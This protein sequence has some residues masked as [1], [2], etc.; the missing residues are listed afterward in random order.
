MALTKEIKSDKIEIVQT[1]NNYP[2]VQVRTVTMIKEDDK[3]ISKNYHRHVLNPNSDLTGEDADVV[4][5]ANAVF[6]ASAK[7]A[8][9]DY[10]DSLEPKIA[11]DVV[12]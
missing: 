2:V 6:T 3:V 8:Y 4:K 10:V 12:E 5:V 11:A 9:Q 1:D 7:T